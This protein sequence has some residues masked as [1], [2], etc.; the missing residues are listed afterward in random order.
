MHNREKTKIRLRSIMVRPY[1]IFQIVPTTPAPVPRACDGV[2]IRTGVYGENYDAFVRRIDVSTARASPNNGIAVVPDHNQWKSQLWKPMYGDEF[3]SSH[4]ENVANLNLSKAI[5]STAMVIIEY[6]DERPR[7]LSFGSAA[8]MSSTVLFTAK[9]LFMGMGMQRLNVY[10][11]P[12]YAIPTVM[13]QLN[14][15]VP[16][17]EIQNCY[18]SSLMDLD[19]LNV[20]LDDDGLAYENGRAFEPETTTGMTWSPA[21]DFAVLKIDSS[22]QI[23][24]NFG[25]Q[26]DCLCFPDDPDVELFNRP[27]VCIGNPNR[28]QGDVNRLFAPKF[29]KH[30]QKLVRNNVEEI[31]QSIYEESFFGFS[32]PAASFGVVSSSCTGTVR[33]PSYA[34]CSC[35]G[36][37]GISGGPVVTLDD[38]EVWRG[39]L[40]GGADMNSVFSCL[41]FLAAHPVAKA[42]YD[43]FVMPDRTQ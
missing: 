19:G 40:V 20:D 12:Y 8:F 27:I 2:T 38:P 28:V 18:K 31:L 15:D 13:D 7:S 16:L 10:V 25:G 33:V 41:F 3:L 24:E 1:E 43:A 37:P 6:Y 36:T 32:G 30:M 21:I 39:C 5:R 26:I 23:P 4:M 14:A 11:V 34:G 35:S 42:A 29:K 17:S 22:N 9:H